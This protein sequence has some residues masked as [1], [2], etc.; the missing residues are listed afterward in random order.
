MSLKQQ[1]AYSE[2]TGFSRLGEH[3]VE[4]EISLLPEEKIQLGKSQALSLVEIKRLE[5]EFAKVK[6]EFKNKIDS[7]KIVVEQSSEMLST[8]CKKVRRTLPCFL[9]SETR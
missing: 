7:H 2:K 4:V 8:G 5:G 6:L 3:E 9:D 1:Q